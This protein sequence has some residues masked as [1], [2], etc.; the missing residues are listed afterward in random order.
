ME[1]VKNLLSILL[2]VRR[3]YLHLSLLLIVMRWQV[4]ILA[5][6]PAKVLGVRVGL[7]ADGQNASINSGEKGLAL[8]TGSTSLVMRLILTVKIT[9]NILD[10][11][12]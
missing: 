11:W 12:N 6:P 2:N 5:S 9:F 7:I 8:T 3:N 10:D 4:R 1:E